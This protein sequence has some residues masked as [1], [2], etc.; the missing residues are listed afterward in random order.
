MNDTVRK[1]Y[2]DVAENYL[3]SREIFSNRKYLDKLV[4]LLPSGATIL[5]IGCGAGVPIDSYLIEKG[6][7]IIGIDI[8]DKQIELAKQHVPQGQYER[9]DMADL[10]AGEYQVDG[11]ISFY[12]IFHTPRQS[13]QTLF[14]KLKT[15]LPENGYLLVTMASTEWEG[16]EDFHGTQMSWSHYDAEKNKEL[17]K[18]A[19]FEIVFDEIDTSGG[20]K[21]LIM[22]AKKI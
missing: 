1:S 4:K 14:K 15:F 20:E 17:I 19:G 9:K 13:H 10:Q 5:D 8:S 21:H 16:T 6:F 7:K 2:N 18:D 12:A 11:V 22:L 3:K